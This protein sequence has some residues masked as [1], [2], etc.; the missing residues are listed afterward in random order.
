MPTSN[1]VLDDLI[2]H[3]NVPAGLRLD[4]VDRR[5]AYMR[6]REITPRGVLSLLL[7]DH[8]AGEI[9][10]RVSNFLRVLARR[11]RAGEVVGERDLFLSGCCLLLASDRD[12]LDIPKELAMEAVAS[13]PSI[14]YYYMIDKLILKYLTDVDVLAAINKGLQ[15]RE[16]EENV[17]SCLE[18]LRLY[19]EPIQAK[20]TSAPKSTL[21]R[22]VRESVEGFVGN[23]D[24]V[25]SKTANNILHYIDITYNES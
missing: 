25:V 10:S 9:A 8:P 4:D 14:A 16:S 13:F 20:K 24:A 23:P 12:G 18:A 5:L 2:R 1:P 19:R 22:E 6:N 11:F 3:W 17:L 7:R 21:V 15:G